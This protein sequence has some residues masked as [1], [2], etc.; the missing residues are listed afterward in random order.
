MNNKIHVKMFSRLA[1]DAMECGTAASVLDVRLSVH[2]S[3]LLIKMSVWREWINRNQQYQSTGDVD[4]AYAFTLY[5]WR[6]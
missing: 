1:V 2:C 5:F 3:T 4:F 6:E